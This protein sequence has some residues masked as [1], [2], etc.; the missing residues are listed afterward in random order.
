MI[1]W[2]GSTVSKGVYLPIASE[3]DQVAQPMLFKWARP[4]GQ[5]A[6]Q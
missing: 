2:C 4:L 3:T 1:Q 5:S 6:M